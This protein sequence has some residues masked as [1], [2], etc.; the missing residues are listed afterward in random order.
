[1]KALISFA[2]GLGICIGVSG[3][4]GGGGTMSQPNQ[5]MQP[6][7]P[8]Q[9]MTMMLGVNDVLAKA[10]VQSETDDPFDIN[11]GVVTVNP[12]ND[13]ESDAASID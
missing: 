9:P 10:K 5:P 13:E 1:M 12:S 8:Q 11:G 3:C 6:M 4:G 2:L 7:Q